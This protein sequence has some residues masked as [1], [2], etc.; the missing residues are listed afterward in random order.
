MNQWWNAGKHDTIVF[1]Q[2][3]NKNL[4]RSIED[5]DFAKVEAFENKLAASKSAFLFL[6]TESDRWIM[7]LSWFE[8][9]SNAW[10]KKHNHAIAKIGELKVVIKGFKYVIET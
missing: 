4:K 8:K 9:E 6:Q 10:K 5:S 3:E 2:K 7:Q 1:L